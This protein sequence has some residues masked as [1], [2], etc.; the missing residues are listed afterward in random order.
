MMLKKTQSAKKRKVVIYMMP[1][2]S[3]VP[4]C[5]MKL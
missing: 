1:E 5:C 2:P 4:A 3:V